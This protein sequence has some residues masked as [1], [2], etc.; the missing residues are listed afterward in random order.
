VP[1]AIKSKGTLTVASDASYPPDEFFGPDGH[2]VIGWDADLAKALAGT[3]GLKANVINVP[4]DSILTGLSSGKYDL[5]VSSF[6]DTKKREQAVDFV[7]YF[8]VGER[9]FTKAQG[10]TS[11]T[12]LSQL[13]GH[14]VAVEKG[15]T[16]ESDAMTQK[17]KCAGK[18]LTVLSFP[19]QNG[20][21]LA[22]SSGR[23]Q[24]GF[25]DAQVAAYFVSKSSGAF[26]RLGIW[27]RALRHRGAENP[28]PGEGAPGRAQGPD[29]E[30]H[31]YVDPLEVARDG[32]RRNTGQA[33]RRDQLN[34][35]LIRARR[36]AGP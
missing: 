1:S 7:D 27:I 21:N 32:R 22:L 6:T 8:S 10:G 34:D 20:A 12:T 28:R 23:A 24:V 16:E 35:R 13:C 3:M 4:F 25:A 18:A 29:E 31:L 17:G 11:V 9:F 14:T 36:A 15:T 30:R 33:E 26:K 2:T 5:G 19:D